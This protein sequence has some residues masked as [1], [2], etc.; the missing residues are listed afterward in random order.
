MMAPTPPPLPPLQFA[1]YAVAAANPA[2]DNST[3]PPHPKR[4]ASI[5]AGGPGLR[6]ATL[7]HPPPK[8]PK[9]PGLLR[10]RAVSDVPALP[11]GAVHASTVTGERGSSYGGGWGAVLLSPPRSLIPG[12]QPS[13]SLLSDGYTP[14]PSRAPDWYL[15]CIAVGGYAAASTMRARAAV[16]AAVLARPLGL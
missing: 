2:A 13:E 1:T 4:A 5:D 14:H 10:P 3:D 6:P 8:P 16:A 12:P 7:L 9:P 11:G 15:P